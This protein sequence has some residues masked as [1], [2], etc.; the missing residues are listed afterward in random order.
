MNGPMANGP[1]MKKQPQ[2][3]TTKLHASDAA[4]ILEVQILFAVAL[5]NS[6]NDSRGYNRRVNLFSRSLAA[7][8]SCLCQREC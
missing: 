1:F 2:F 3:L 4:N 6:V 8:L 5:L 7:L